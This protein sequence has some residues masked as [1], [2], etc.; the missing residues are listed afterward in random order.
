MRVF[1]FALVIG[2]VTACTCGRPQAQPGTDGD[3]GLGPPCFSEVDC[4]LGEMCIA[5]HC[6]SPQTEG[7]AATPCTRN[8]ECASGLICVPSTGQCISPPEVD[9]GD[10]GDG[11][12]STALCEEGQALSCG[13]SKLGECRLGTSTCAFVD[14]IWQFGPCVGAVNPVTE[15]CNGQDDDCDGLIDDGLG[16]TSCGMGACAR[17]V[18]MCI[19]GQGS[20]C[21][22]GPASAEVCDGLDN[23]C[24]GQVDDNVPS[25]TCG[26]GECARVA[27]GCV[28][29]SPGTC[30][31]GT[32]SP[33]SCNGLDDDCDGQV[34]DGIGQVSCGVGICA[35]TIDRCV[36]GV[37]QTCTP[38]PAG[39]EACNGLDDDCDSQTDENFGNLSCGTGACTRTV[40]ACVNGSPQLC[41][42]GTPS[43]ET[44]NGSDDDCDGQTDEGLGS[45]T[46]GT[47]VCRRTVTTCVG[48]APQMCTPGPAGTET[49]NGLDDD[50]NGQTDDGLTCNCTDG[51]TQPC[52]SGPS[53]TQ[54]VGVCRGG[55]RTCVSGSWSIC[56]GEVV[57][58]TETCNGRDDDCNAQ[59][60]EDLG[61]TTCGTGIC[62]R[63]VNNC[64]GGVTQTCTPG[65]AGTETCNGLDDDCNG[66][67]D[68]GLGTTTCGTG[69]CLRTVNN[70]AGGVTQTCTPGASSAETCNGLDDD[71]DGQTDEGLG[72]TTCGTGVCLRTVNNCV[73]GAPQTCTPGT[74]GTETCNGLDDDCDG[75][76]DEGLGQT[77]CG[78]GAC[79]VTIAACVNGN[80][81]TCVPGSPTT[82]VCNNIDDDCDGPVDETFPQQGQS[83]S[84]GLS[85][86]CGNGQRQCTSGSLVCA[87]TVFPVNEVCNNGIDENCNGTVDDPMSC[88][89]NSQIDA[90]LDGANQCVD[91]NDNDGTVYPGRTELCNGKDDDCDGQLD[92]GFDQ[93]GDCFTT[94]GTHPGCKSSTC[95]QTYG[96]CSAALDAR[97]VDCNDNN[98]FVFPLKTA[99]CG[100]QATP[101][102]AN[103]VDD[104]CNGYV[105]ETCGCS[106]QD[107]D[108]D[109]VTTCQGDC[110]DNDAT[111]APGRTEVCDGKDNDCNQ[112]T[113]DNCGVSDPCG[114]KQGNNWYRWPAGTDQCRPDLICVS[115]VATGA[116]TC[117][118]FC[119]QTVGAGLNDS[120]A[121]GEGC[122]RNLLDSDNLHLCSVLSTGSSTTGQACS[123]SSQC[124]SGDCLTT[125]GPTDYCSDKCTHQAGCSAN[126]TCYI[127]RNS[128]GFPMVTGYYLASWCRL[129]S[130]I[131]GTKT[132]GQSCSGSECKSGQYGCFNGTCVEPCCANADCPSGYVCTI[133]GPKQNTGYTSGGSQIWSVM[134]SC[135]A[136]NASRVSAQ[137]C[138]A[139]SQCKSGICDRASNVCVDLCCN[140]SSCPSGTTCEMVNFKFSTGQITSIRACV[141]P[142][143]PALVEQR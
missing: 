45:T 57:P 65:T 125:D 143:T 98:N 82:E 100:N 139:S 19:G 108:G 3:E 71:C 115:N 7:D 47:G 120:C 61:T 134:P 121:V 110:N 94:C 42:P 122:Y 141:L 90:D 96:S 46:C 44:C 30:T 93:D 24:N 64:A 130:N 140:D 43:T 59:T 124:R 29:G 101:T 23:D 56:V 95:A 17:T 111:I 53:G 6:G 104:N 2:A 10:T 123:G 142:P 62:Q 27:Q 5:G 109:G 74:A 137:A 72:Q 38:G 117:G 77:T 63:T 31:P 11:G 133:D 68:E 127:E 87:Q 66:Q 9:S 51:Q 28:N 138:T 116:L 84:T 21:V 39:T 119:N 105:D 12:F 22:P 25:I 20:T 136:S 118:S 86:P 80:P 55:T 69:V 89:C 128:L 97:R 32:P 135:V 60:D 113:V 14:G 41:T 85:G 48:G 34:D 36:N 88:G 107:R 92:E 16:T 1:A 37:P 103:G 52:Y 33:E 114:Y 75:Q 67:T 73:G 4:A 83:C 129:T 132:L 15:S 78:T 13:S 91:C 81:Q 26:I 126:T 106:A 131:T 8:E 102:T 76:T 50:C 35:R 58:T 99:D 70:C 112:R 49:C 18:D 40:A 79:Q 54:N